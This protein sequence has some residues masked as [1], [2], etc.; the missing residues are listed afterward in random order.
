MDQEFSW[1]MA[2]V[3]YVYNITLSSTTKKEHYKKNGGN[4]I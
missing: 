3:L 1:K 2:I 4:Y